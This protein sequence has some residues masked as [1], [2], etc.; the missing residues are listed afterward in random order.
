MRLSGIAPDLACGDAGELGVG[1]LH[2]HRDDAIALGEAVDA[3]T[4]LA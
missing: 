1:A 4:D 3:V 2:H